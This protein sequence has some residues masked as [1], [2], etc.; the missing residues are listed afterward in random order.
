MRYEVIESKRWVNTVTGRTASLYGAVPW[1]TEAEKDQW[2]VQSAGWTVRDN[3]N[4]TVGI[5]RLPWPTKEEAQTWAN[6]ENARLEEI[7]C[8]FAA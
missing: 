2:T 1:T 6:K 8:R 4:G 5:G 7:R 3:K